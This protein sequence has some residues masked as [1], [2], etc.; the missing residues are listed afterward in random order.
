MSCKM[1]S[2]LPR[3]VGGSSFFFILFSL[4]SIKESRWAGKHHVPHDMMLSGLPRLVG[5]L[6]LPLLLS[7]FKIRTLLTACPPPPCHKESQWARKHHVFIFTL[8][9]SNLG[10]CTARPCNNKGNLASCT[11][12]RQDPDNYRTDSFEGFT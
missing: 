7:S 11:A 2:G 8:L 12:R 3:L 4:L 1:L 9:Q 6:L 10:S 5:D